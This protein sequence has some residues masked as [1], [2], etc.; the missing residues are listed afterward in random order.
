M[1]DL[2]LVTSRGRPPAPWSAEQLDRVEQFAEG[3][4]GVVV[5]LLG[6]LLQLL[7]AIAD[8]V[9]SSRWLTEDLAQALV[10]E[11][12]RL[13]Q[14]ELQ[15]RY[16][17]ADLAGGVAQARMLSFLRRSRLRM[18]SSP[19]AASMSSNRMSGSSVVA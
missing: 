13:A 10:R 12:H 4:S 6:S 18:R 11:G 17:V 1:N 5:P 14:L 3:L 7:N 19:I 8:P 9:L 2:P 16:E 15:D